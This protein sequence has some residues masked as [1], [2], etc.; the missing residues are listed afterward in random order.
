M[1]IFF[2]FIALLIIT[3][4]FLNGRTME[5]SGEKPVFL[6]TDIIAEKHDTKLEIKINSSY[7]PSAYDLEILEK[8]YKNI[9]AHL[10]HLYATNDVQAGKEYFTEDW[11]KQI[12]LYYKGTKKPLVTRYD[13]QHELHIQN[14]ASDALVCTAIDSNVVLRT[15]YPDQTVRITKTTIAVVLLFQGDHWRLDALRVLNENRIHAA[16]SGLPCY[17]EKF[18]LPA[19]IKKT[20]HILFS[21]VSKQNK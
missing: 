9:W 13:E 3:L 2:T 17:D 16:M 15:N 5:R 10:N 19:T 8:D 6:R 20:T 11:F 1:K 21:K 18:D 7:K 4:L 14:W 12:C